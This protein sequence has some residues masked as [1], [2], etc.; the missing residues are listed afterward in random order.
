MYWKKVVKIVIIE[1][2]LREYKIVGEILI[3]KKKFVDDFV[4]FKYM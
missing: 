1:S 2:I 4:F 3:L